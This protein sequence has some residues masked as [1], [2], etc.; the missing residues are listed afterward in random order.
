[1]PTRSKALWAFLCVAIA[2]S[3]PSLSRSDS[4]LYRGDIQLRIWE[5][6]VPYGDTFSHP[7]IANALSGDSVNL[8]GMSPARF[9]LPAGQ[10]GLSTS[11][12]DTSPPQPSLLFLST[13]FDGANDSAS[14]FGGGAAGPAAF[15]PLPSIPAS[16]FGVTLGA[17]QGFGGVMK[18]L[19][20]FDWRGVLASGCTYCSYHTIVPLTPIGGPFGNTATAMAYVGGTA[21][22][23]TFVTA[24]IWGFP[25]QTGDVNAV[26]AVDSTASQTNT[27]ATGMDQRSASGL[28][29]LQLVTP[30]LVRVKST[31]AGCQNCTS[32]WYYAGSAKAELRFTPEAGASIL[33]MSGLVGLIALVGRSRTR[34]NDSTRRR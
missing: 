6:N 10:F 15:T 21:V 12:F 5:R 4:A 8:T 3:V 20:E 26:A 28:G 1:M 34:D 29:T 17:S 33:L 24:T 22:P 9:D 19:G 14:F 30:F 23:P 31:P 32:H 27:A 25:W 16:E 11:N 7:R 13:R 2:A 18:L